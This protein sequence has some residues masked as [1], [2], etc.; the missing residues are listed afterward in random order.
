LS[1]YEHDFA[2]T[3]KVLTVSVDRSWRIVPIE[4]SESDPVTD[5]FCPMC[6]LRFVEPAR[7]NEQAERA[8]LMT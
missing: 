6:L 8:R 2:I 1:V 7:A 4:P 3:F 5:T